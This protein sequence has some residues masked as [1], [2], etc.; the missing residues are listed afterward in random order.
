[1]V[2][3]VNISSI[4]VV[5]KIDCLM[6]KIFSVVFFLFLL[7]VHASAQRYNYSALRN[8]D[9]LFQDLD[10]GDLC[11]A[12]EQVTTSYKGRHFSHLGLVCIEK[13]TI[14][15]IEAIGEK[16]KKTLLKDFVNR[17]QNEILLGRVKARYQ[18][19]IDKVIHYAQ[20]QIGLPYDDAF[21]YGNGQYYCSELVYDAFKFG[22]GQKDF[23]V[24]EPMTFKQPHNKEFFPIWITYFKNLSMPIPEALPGIN[25]GGISTSSRLRIYV[26]R[27]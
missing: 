19:I 15:V 1:M 24:L 27:R 20:G 18:K 6:Q 26:F 8:G 21:L 13:D 14:F 9:L 25:P 10:C 23:F 17:N 4:A 11:D 12:I 3:S 7:D 22:Y 5:T 2:C 16:V